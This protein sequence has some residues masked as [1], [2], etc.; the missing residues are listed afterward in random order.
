[1]ETIM[2]KFE[3]LYESFKSKLNED[4]SK[5]DME[6][7]FKSYLNTALWSTNDNSDDSGGNPLDNKY[8]I[9]DFSKDA[10]KKAE[11][12]VKKFVSDLEKELKKYN[13]SIKD[14]DEIGRASCRERV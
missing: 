2:S 1:M 5:L 8:D 3:N 14:E 12:Y 7:V 6:R 9:D 4:I 10:L 13:D 11:K